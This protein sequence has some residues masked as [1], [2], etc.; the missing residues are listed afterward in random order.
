[1]FNYTV[2]NRANSVKYLKSDNFPQ[3]S[4]NVLVY[5]FA[6]IFLLL[7]YITFLVAINI[8]LLCESFS[9]VGSPIFLRSYHSMLPLRSYSAFFFFFSFEIMCRHYKD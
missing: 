1:M 4:L 6:L 8:V 5:F 9:D 3:C 2:E 7:I